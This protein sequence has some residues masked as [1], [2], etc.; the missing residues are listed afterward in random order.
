MPHT[1]GDCCGPGPGGLLRHRRPHLPA[2]PQRGG[3]SAPGPYGSAEARGGRVPRPSN[4][5]A[6][7]QQ[8][9]SLQLGK[10]QGMPA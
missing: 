4:C 2:Q 5:I 9:W 7:R 1:I 6:S 3:G 10:R 8:P